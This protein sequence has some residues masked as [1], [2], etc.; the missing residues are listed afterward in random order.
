MET[1]YKYIPVSEE[2]I[3]WGLW[4]LCAGCSRIEGAGGYPLKS[5]PS[6]HY[7]NWQNGRVLQ[8]YQLIYITRGE[9]CFESKSSGLKT[10]KGGSVILLF[11]GEW[12]RYKPNK[13]TGWDEYWIGISGK[14][15]D[16][17]LEKK[18]FKPENPLME[19]GFDEQLFNLFT[20]IIDKTKHEKHGFQTVI[21]GS[22]FHLLGHLYALSKESHFQNIHLEEIINKAKMVF[23]AN[24]GQEFSSENVAEELQ[25]GYSWFRKAFK[26][27]TGMAPGQYF[28]QLKIQKAKELLSDPQ[29]TVKCIAY[30]LKFDSI[31]Y[32][33]KLFKEK[34]GLTPIQFKNQLHKK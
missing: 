6:H 26:T 8:E 4:V 20:E 24:I 12:H 19:I 11:P 7:F 30:E 15:I 29:Q 27:Y 22:A 2:E 28:I 34:T 23:R 31:F 13:H 3:N 16:N 33:S 14:I 17:L 5:H 32:F 18:F 1:Y 25:V 9:G 21:S 10:I